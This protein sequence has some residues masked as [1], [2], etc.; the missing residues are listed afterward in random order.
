MS[1]EMA[2]TGSKSFAWLKNHRLNGSDGSD[3]EETSDDSFNPGGSVHSDDSKIADNAKGKE[4]KRVQ[5]K[6]QGHHPEKSHAERLTGKMGDDATWFGAAY[7]FA[8]VAKADCPVCGSGESPE[9][10]IDKP[11]QEA[12]PVQHYLEAPTGNADGKNGSVWPTERK[13]TTPYSNQQPYAPIA[14]TDAMTGE[15]GIWGQDWGMS[16][17]E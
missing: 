7:F 13:R 11:H 10:S 4:V 3:N 5:K 8:L 15:D 2:K 1:D 14:S 17:A 16:L 9:S 12:K 6:G